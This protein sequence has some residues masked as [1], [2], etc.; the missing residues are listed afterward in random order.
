MR[1][2]DLS[3]RIDARG[4]NDEVRV[5]ADSFDRMLDRLEDAFARQ[6]GFV[7]DASHELRTPLT[8]IRGQLEVLAR[9]GEV[10]PEDVRHVDEVVR[11][12]VVR[13]ERL[14][15]DLL[16]LARA[17]EGEL[18][19]PASLDLRPF[20]TELFDSLTLTAERRF[21]LG[22]VPD[23]TL[24]ADEDRLAQV[25]R[26]LGRNAV[27]HTGRTGSCACASRRSRAAGS[28]SPSRTTVP[29]SR[30]SSATAC[31]TASTVSTARAS[32]ARAV[33]G[34]GSRSRVRSSR[35][36]AGASPPARRRRAGRASHSYCPA[37][38]RPVAPLESGASAPATAPSPAAARRLIGRMWRNWAGDQRC[39]PVA[40]ERPAGTAEIAAV[41]E[42]AAAA[43]E[44]VRVAGSGHS[45]TDAAC[46]DGRL[47]TLE[48]MDRVVDVDRASGLVR[49]EGG[50]TIHALSAAL[51]SHGLA[52]ENLGDIDV[53]SIS[54]AI[55]TATHGTGARLRNISAQVESVELVLADG[56]TARSRRPTPIRRRTW[57]RASASAAS[58]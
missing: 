20:V 32:A 35:R 4:R 30:P 27:E 15:E 8:V 28:R 1:A 9:Q 51:A 17:D 7:A 10:T 22:D 38:A 14:V 50:I 43:G 23:G 11:T 19:R 36:M 54:G 55:S 41:L 34:S 31:S 13:M 46:T 16:L 52:F 33:P 57:R 6:R 56:S 18:L 5:L 45:F 42:R 49:V 29:G 44:R 2:G 48:R 3:K 25:V 58:A 37:S 40:I 53:Q 24:R 39:A 12:E 26:N 21:E 47:L